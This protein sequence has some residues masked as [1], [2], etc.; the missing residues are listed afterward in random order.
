MVIF[1]AA[2]D[3]TKRKLVPA[4]YNLAKAQL[5]PKEF[6]VVGIARNEMTTEVFR[7]KL[8][9]DFA[10]FLSE[11]VDQTLLDWVIRR[12]YY[13]TGA[14]SDPSA[15]QQ[16]G[17]E[18][19]KVNKEHGTAGNYLFY[20]A[21]NPTF[22]S[23]IVRQLGEARLIAEE[24]GQWR[25]VIIEK[26]FGRDL[27]SARALNRE[28]AKTLDERQIYRIDHYLG[29]ETVQNI[30]VF[31]FGNS[32]FE[33]IWDRRYIDH[34][35]ITVAETV[36]VEQRGLYYEEAGALRDMIPNHIFQL[37]ALIAMEPPISFDADAV[38]DEKAKVLRAIT[39]IEPEDV[40]TRAVRGQYG[41]GRNGNSMPSYK[42]E[43][44]VAAKSTTETYAA[45]KVV[46]A[47]GDGP[48]FRFMC[49]P[50]S[51]CRSA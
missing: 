31:R 5:L 41:P 9:E 17:A 26:P 44:N 10:S 24:N 19:A 35:Q 38:R 27:D 18:I 25:R 16:L 1:G 23:D 36:G 13:V 28:I 50:V 37:I 20:L 48:T 42:A 32:I 33:P 46:I 51:A 49:E 21:T 40:L 3:L 14:F 11:P 30:M 39:P 22:F 15:Y 47:T 8:E 6:A 7:E 45:L 34:V 12:L 29:K 4:L 2:G 43:L